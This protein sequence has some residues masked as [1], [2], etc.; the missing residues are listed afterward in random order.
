[1]FSPDQYELID[2]GDGRKLERVGELIL[3]RPSP[4][5]EAVK[6]RVAV[7]NWRSDARYERTSAETGR[8]DT[9]G[10][11]PESWIVKHE[12]AALELERTDFGH[13]GLFPEQ[14]ENWDWIAEQ[15]RQS[16]RPLKVLNLFAYTGGST[17][18]AA[19][20]GAEVVH[21][22]AARNVVS[23]ARRNAELSGLSDAKIRWITEDAVRFVERE[24]KRG[25]SYD[26]VISDPPSY[27]H[28]PNGEVWQIDDGLGPLLD[29]CLRLTADRLQ[30]MLLTCHS[31]TYDEAVLRKLLDERVKSSAVSVSSGEMT[32]VTADGRRLPSG[33]FARVTCKESGF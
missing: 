31:P 12:R 1:M 13:I 22:D 4:A 5:V 25:N 9:N 33:A 17:L 29:G 7:S 32:L 10:S 20:A 2:F 19:A 6:P 24:L 30:F 8:W 15:V 27:G 28:G 23:W 16:P 26:A 18:A 11:L 21:I 3:A 14:A